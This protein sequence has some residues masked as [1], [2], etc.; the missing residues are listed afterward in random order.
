MNLIFDVALPTNL[1]GKEA[2][3]HQAIESGLNHQ[4]NMTYH[5]II[6]YDASAFNQ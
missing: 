3:I 6:N 5:V 4:N 2:E 1:K